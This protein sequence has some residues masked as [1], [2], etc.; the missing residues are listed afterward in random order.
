M[1]Q[2]L[3][4]GKKVGTAIAGGLVILFGFVLIP[5]P[6]PGWLIVF[7]GFAILATEFAFAGR[8]LAW[9]K[10]KYE[11]WKVWLKRQPLYLRVLVLGFTGLVILITA[12][13]LNT[14]GLINNFLHLGQ[15]WLHS[16]FFRK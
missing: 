4:N 8:A 14:F 7:A 3:R 5:Y 10:G 11:Q 15:D 13:L 12:W 6:G 16:P 1:N 9:L 2:A